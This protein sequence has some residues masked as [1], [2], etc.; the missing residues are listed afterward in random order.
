MLTLDNT[1]FVGLFPHRKPR[2]RSSPRIDDFGI[3]SRLTSNPFVH[4]LSRV[5]LYYSGFPPKL[6]G[7]PCASDVT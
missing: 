7:L 3:G 2:T 6:S 4:T 5:E 1:A